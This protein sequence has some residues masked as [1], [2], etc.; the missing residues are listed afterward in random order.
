MDLFELTLNQQAYLAPVS[1]WRVIDIP[2]AVKISP[3]NPNYSSFCRM[4]RQLEKG[5]VLKSYR[6]PGGGRKYIY[7]T[8]LGERLMGL[9]EAPTSITTETLLHDLRASELAREL[10]SRGWIDSVSL[11]HELHNKRQFGSSGRIV[12]D[13]HL[14]GSK[15]GKRFKIALE[16]ELT[17]KSH[18]RVEEKIRHYQSQSFYDY[19]LYFFPKIS[20]LE[21][22]QEFV[23]TRIGPEVSKRLMCFCWDWGS[24]LNESKGYFKGQSMTLKELFA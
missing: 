4:V 18:S 24:P 1:Q 7:L 13:A 21:N 23:T 22:F 20:H 8:P 5:G 15:S 17:V 16:V 14:E 2:S 19:C 10:L 3:L 12:P 9:G 6:K 11:E